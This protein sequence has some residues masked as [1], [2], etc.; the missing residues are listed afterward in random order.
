MRLRAHA[1]GL[2]HQPILSSAGREKEKETFTLE[3]KHV[4]SSEGE[5]RVS[6]LPNLE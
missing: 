6:R 1:E 4:F 3:C 2:I 5:E